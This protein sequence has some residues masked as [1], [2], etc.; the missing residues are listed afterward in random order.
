MTA[1]ATHLRALGG[2]GAAGLHFYRM[3]S[4]FMAPELRL[5]DVVAFEPAGRFQGDGL[6]VLDLGGEPDVYRCAWRFGTK[7]IDVWRD[8]PRGP[9]SRSSVDE[10]RFGE[11]VRGRVVATVK[12]Y[13]GYFS[14]MPP[15]GSV[16]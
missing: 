4:H 5:G 8:G 2:P 3:A 6:Y 1:T 15:P 12:L 14:E 9:R 11:I 13:G 10:A 7:L 16:W